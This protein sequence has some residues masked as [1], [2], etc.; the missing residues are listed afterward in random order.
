MD[1]PAEVFARRRQALKERLRQERLPAL[2]VSHAANRWYLSGFEL[3]DS[4]CNES[5]GWLVITADG[6]DHLLTDPRFEEAARRVWPG[7]IVIYTARKLD[8]IGAFLDSLAPARLGF[9]PKS[10]C[11]RDYERLRENAAF[12]PTE[13]LVEDLRA[14][15]DPGEIA[16]LSASCALNHKVMEALPGRLV[17]GM[18][19]AEAAWLVERLFREGGASALAFST[20]VGAGVNAAL[21]HAEPGPAR[22]PEEGPVLVDC[23]GRLHNYCSDQTRTFWLGAKPSDR[24]R[25]TLD[26]VREAQNRA[27]RFIGPGVSIAETY[28]LA[29]Q[30]FEEQGLAE[31][32]THGLGHG[33]GLE[34]HEPPSLPS[35]SRDVFRPGMVVAVEP[36]L[37]WPDWGGV[38]WEYMV[39]VTEDGCRVL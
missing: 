25:T 12:T 9:E 8:K 7:N 23:G 30:C 29:R 20:I 33:V 37:Y 35:L 17:P 1:T 26:L 4:Q 2:L 39:L 21:P 19:E 27:L 10:L 16:L 28:G 22:L 34:T 11:V 15:K 14:I 38:R 18:T 32:F 3:M 6:E 5:A 24:F 13:N 36:G 31:R